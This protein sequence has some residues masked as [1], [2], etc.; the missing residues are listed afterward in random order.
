MKSK[1][2]LYEE[3][4]ALIADIEGSADEPDLQSHLNT[5]LGVLQWVVGDMS[6]DELLLGIEEAR[7][8]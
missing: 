5:V 6:V 3:I 4:D 1:E 8:N 2:E 7:G